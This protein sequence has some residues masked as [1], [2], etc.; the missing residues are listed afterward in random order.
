[1]RYRGCRHFVKRMDTHRSPIRRT[2]PHA[3]LRDSLVFCRIN[4][5]LSGRRLVSLP[6]SDHCEPL[7]ENGAEL[8]ALTHRAE[9]ELENERSRYVEIRPLYT[10]LSA[11]ISL[12]SSIC[13]YSLH[14]L[15][16]QPDLE[17]L[18]KNCHSSTRR[19]IRRARRE[20]L[21]Y[22]EGHSQSLLEVFLRLNV[23]TRRRH[24]APPQPKE[25]F[26]NLLNCF[27]ES[28]KI[29][30]AFHVGRPM[31]AIITLRHRDTVT[32]KYSCSDAHY[33]NLGGTHFLM[34][35]T[36]EEAKH[37]GL[38][39]FDLGRSEFGNTGLLTFKDRWGGR[40]STL[41]YHRIATSTR[42]SSHYQT[43]EPGRTARFGQELISRLPD[44]ALLALGSLVYKH[45]G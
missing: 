38:R 21:T 40:R 37:E 27:G 32:Y 26:K 18:F 15:D 34:W 2:A 13:A 42:S 22:V 16:L 6:F 12:S 41:S 9:G 30:A 44:R 8:R 14:R 39:V 19:N 31:A 10:D 5:W 7:V 29:R 25:W 17:T 24:Q 45:I 20:R 4:S 36:I 1:M 23:S 11:A 35:K 33:K 28:L 3:D 43:A